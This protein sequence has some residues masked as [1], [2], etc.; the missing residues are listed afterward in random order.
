MMT[1]EERAAT[2]ARYYDI[3]TIDITYDAELYQQLAHQAGGPVLELAV[4]SGRLAIPLA[5]AGHQVVGIDDDAAMLAR[6]RR[7]WRRSRGAVDAERLTLLEGD[8]ST[9]RSET[10]F[11]LA[12]IAVNTFL[13]LPGDA[14]RLAV[15][16]MMRDHLR[17]GGIAAVEVSAPDQAEL[18]EYDGRLQLEW[19]RVDPETGDEVTKS[20]SARYDP[21]AETVTITQ[22]FESHPTHGGPL[23]RVSRTDVLHLIDAADLG[24]LAREA[25]FG[26]VGSGQDYLLR[27]PGARSH[28]VILVARSV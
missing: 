23:R 14:E 13:L 10:R 15:L 2:L 11:G 22:L 28:R 16:G 20:I 18:A 25:G 17:S 19:L 1:P 5:L 24:R 3:D 4:G 21:E 27:S 26:D 7:A 8:L 6:A 9:F 12:F